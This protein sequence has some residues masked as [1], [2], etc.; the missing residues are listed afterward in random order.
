[1]NQPSPTAVRRLIFDYG[2]TLDTNGLHWAHVLWQAYQIVGIPV[3]EQQFREA[4]VF[5]ERSLAKRPIITPED[6]FHDLLVKKLTEELSFLSEQGQLPATAAALSDLARSVADV[7][8]A[9]VKEVMVMT[10]QML[11]AVSEVYRP[12]LV[13]NFYGNMHSVLRDFGILPYFSA[14]IESAVCGVRKP[15]SEIFRL[16]VEAAGVP[17]E[18]VCVVGD[19]LSK[20]IVPA[21]SIGCKTMWLRGR[22]WDDE[23]LATCTGEPADVVIDSIAQVPEAL[24]LL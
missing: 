7:C 4:Y 14:V 6:N 23:G 2:G 24:S 8:Y 12:V 3:S 10:R 17:P 15:D 11:S 22:G 16:G 5:G 9:H 19:S 18:E 20:D 1:M 13:S 21:H